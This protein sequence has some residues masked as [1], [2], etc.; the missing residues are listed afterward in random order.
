MPA[1]FIRQTSPFV[2]NKTV[3]AGAALNDFFNFLNLYI[4]EQKQMPL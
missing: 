1:G 2:R 4:Y 3:K